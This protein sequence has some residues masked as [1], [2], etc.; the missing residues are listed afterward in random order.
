MGVIY[1]YV[2]Y[3]RFVWGSTKSRGAEEAIA[4]SLQR[5]PLQVS[6]QQTI[7]NVS[8]GG[9]MSAVAEG[10]DEDALLGMQ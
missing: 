3:V 8:G 6:Q 4:N 5:V 10:M 1:S 7:G 2:R 9:P